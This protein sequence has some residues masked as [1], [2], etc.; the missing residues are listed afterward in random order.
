MPSL[1]LPCVRR[2]NSASSMPSMALKVWIGGMVASPTPT[3]PISSDS[4]S[5]MVQSRCTARDSAAAAIQ[6][7]DP[8]PTTTMRRRLR[9]MSSMGVS[10]CDDASG[11]CNANRPGHWRAAG[12]VPGQPR[13]GAAR[14][15][16]QNAYL[17]VALIVRP[18]S[19]PPTM[20]VL[21]PTKP[22]PAAGYTLSNRL[23]T[24]TEPVMPRPKS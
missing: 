7:A 23:F 24:F 8:P 15:L 16:R 19:A 22:V 10:W 1:K 17:T 2:M 3:V 21:P 12:R 6:P 5:T 9:L 4:I 13:N 20:V 11:L 14:P 18:V